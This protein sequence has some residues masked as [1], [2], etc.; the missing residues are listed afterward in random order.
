MGW[1]DKTG[2]LVGFLGLVYL[3][4]SF[5]GVYFLRRKVYISLLCFCIFLINF[6]GLVLGVFLRGGDSVNYLSR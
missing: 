2:V 3:V 5:L 6:N 4:C 1:E